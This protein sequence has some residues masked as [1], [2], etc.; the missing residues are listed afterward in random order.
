MINLIRFLLG[1]PRY[2]VITIHGYISPYMTKS[3]AKQFSI[4]TS[5]ISTPSVVIGG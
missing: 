3:Q 5:L 4:K 1:L 2:R